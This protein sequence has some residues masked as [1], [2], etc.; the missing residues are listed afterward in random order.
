MEIH[1]LVTAAGLN[2]ARTT[3]SV[4]W[5]P[6]EVACTSAIAGAIRKFGSEIVSAALTNLAV[7]FA[8]Q[9]LTHGGA[10]F[11][12]LVR[13]LAHRDPD[14]DPDRLMSALQTRTSDEW[15]SFTVGSL[16][17]ERRI[18][19]LHAAIRDIYD[20]VPVAAA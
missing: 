3:S 9:K 13:I 15:G 19:A 12:A 20:K 17:G 10:I 7:A 8:D 2:I 6:G 11:G 4:A 5:R 16:G 1:Q 18:A 14:F